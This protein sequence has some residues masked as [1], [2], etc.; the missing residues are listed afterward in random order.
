MIREKS[1]EWGGVWN[2]A[3]FVGRIGGK[4]V[5]R[6]KFAKD[7]VP[8]ALEMRSDDDW[9]RADGM[10][11][12][13]VVVRALDQVGNILPYFNAPVRFTL[14]GPGKVLG[15]TESVLIGGATGLWLRAAF[16]KGTLVLDVEC[17]GFPKTSVKV[18][19]R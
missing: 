15:P 14:R 7:P 4:V 17:P 8:A 3:L 13:R 19:V 10:D 6:K 18:Q 2:E 9:L 16:K 11:A 5:A 12:T 1:G